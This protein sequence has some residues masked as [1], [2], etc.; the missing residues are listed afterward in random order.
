MMV[1]GM[2]EPSFIKHDNT[3]ARP[4]R[5]YGPA[6]LVDIIVTNPP[7]SVEWKRTA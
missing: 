1:H 2:E 4:L 7:R 6:D 3:L 5:D